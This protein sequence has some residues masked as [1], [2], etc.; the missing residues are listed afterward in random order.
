MQ[1][2]DP[3]LFD[4]AFLPVTL[5]V[6]LLLVEEK[7]EKLVAE[8]LRDL[9]FRLALLG[10]SLLAADQPHV[11]EMSLVRVVV[12]AD[13]HFL[14]VNALQLLL[15]VLDERHLV[16]GK[17]IEAAVVA[18]DTKLL[19]GARVA[20]DLVRVDEVLAV[21]QLAPRVARE[22]DAAVTRVENVFRLRVVC[23]EPEREV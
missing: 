12:P 1:P 10:V 16:L 11:D 18:F 6:E 22:N 2:P 20:W 19:L 15:V 23:R 4:D 13:L 5:R 14:W 8:E 21:L 17:R 3:R 7:E 9:F